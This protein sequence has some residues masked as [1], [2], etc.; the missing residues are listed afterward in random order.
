MSSELFKSSELYSGNYP[1]TNI[2][3]F[4]V[5][6]SNNSTM[7]YIISFLFTFL[8]FNFSIAQSNYEEGYIIRNSGDTVFGKID[9]RNWKLNPLMIRFQP[10]SSTNQSFDPSSIKEFHIQKEKETYRSF[11]VTLSQLPGESE[12]AVEYNYK[13]SSKITRRVFLLVLVNHPQICLYQYNERAKEHYF[14]SKGE[15]NPIELIHYYSFDDVSNQVQETSL[16]RDQVTSITSSCTEIAASIQRLKY[17]QSDLQKFF[18]KYLKC[19]SPDTFIEQIKQE[20][21]P[22][23]FGVV[24]GGM[25]N[26]YNFKGDNTALV[27]NGYSSNFSPVIGISLDLGLARNQNK[28]HIINEL[29]YK[30]YK[31]GDSFVRPYG[32]GYNYTYDISFN[33]SYLQLN[34]LVRYL[35]AANSSIMPYVNFGIGNGFMISQKE[36]KRVTL[37]SFNGAT[38]FSEAINGP[39]KYEFS[40]MGGGGIATGKITL[41]FRYAYCGKSFTNSITSNVNV[42]SVQLIGNYRF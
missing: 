21:I 10:A 8:I 36:N 26:S 40:L 4:A 23:V 27:N 13:D 3:T 5:S 6:I 28:W 35:F 22:A 12:K 16:F 42:G 37:D 18:V 34:N 19:S 29:I 1:W 9:Y 11:T 33:F 41:E 38:T 31:T 17:N 24:I 14:Y 2:L 20:R 7:K 25:L 15:E 30:N 32:G 39:K